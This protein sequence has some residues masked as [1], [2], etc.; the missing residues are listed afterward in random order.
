MANFEI[1][2][3]LKAAKETD[4]FKPFE[5]RDFNSGWQN[6]RYRFNAISG[7]N[8]FALEISGGKWTDDKKNKILTLSK[9]EPGKKAGKLEIAWADRKNP[10][11]IDQVAGFR[12]YTCNLLT[13]DE[14][15]ALEE[16]GKA[17]EAQKKNHQFLEKTEYASLVK[18]VIDS[19]KYADAKFR[20]LGT[21]DFQY[22]ETKG[23]YY[24][25][26]SVDKM[27]RVPD[28]TPY[29]AEMTIN[30]FYTEDAVDAES[31][32]ET[33]KM[34]FNC[35]T[36]Y[37]FSSIKANRFVPMT[38]VINGNGGEQSEKKAAGFKKTL[39][40]FDD[41][42]TVRKIG[43]VC[44]MIDGAE[45]QAITYDDLDEDTRDNID[46]GLIELEDAIKA[47]G[48][49][50]MGQRV[51]EYRVKSLARNSAKGSEPTVYTEEDLCK[52]PVVETVEEE[53]DI[54]ADSD[55]DDDFDI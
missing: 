47:L 21:V 55:D 40:K 53:I 49:N 45:A 34:L 8:R 7:N 25:T 19:G 38:L 17:E 46:M 33:K 30:T 37:Y 52:L 12:V 51:S 35:Y 1:I 23:Q 18:K 9:A 20:I 44:D 41:D 14:R 22:S 42:A 10:E 28:D 31:Y 6:T 54:F 11:K 3:T 39:A 4:T 29:K 32:D 43:L 50:V 36:D 2:A 13:F 16:A 48:G 24:R 27:Y 26:F 5:V 15:K